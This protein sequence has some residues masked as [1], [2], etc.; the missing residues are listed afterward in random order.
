MKEIKIKK[1]NEIIY[2]YKTKY[3]LDVYIWPYD[4]SDQISLSLN[5]KYGSIHTEFNINNKD[6]KV[7]N[8]IA[9]FLE[10]IKFNVEKDVTAHDIYNKLG[11]YVNAYTTYDHTSYEVV[12][13]DNI[14]DNILNLLKF[15]YN[16]YF[17]KGLISK[18]KPIII[19]EAKSVLDD[20]YNKGYYALQQ[21]IFKNSKYKNIITGTAVEVK[22]IT[23]E[24][25]LNV[26]NGF[27]HPK[28]SFLVVTGNVNPLEV[29]KI[30]DEYF[31]NNKFDEYVKPVLKKVNEDSKVIKKSEIIDSYVTKEK[32]IM[33]FKYPKKLFKDFTRLDLASFIKII[34]IFNFDNSSVLREYLDSNCIID[35]LYYSIEVSEDSV[36]IYFEVS[37]DYCKEVEEKIL[38]QMNNLYVSND[39]FLLQKKVMIAETIL[40]FDSASQVNDRIKMDILN[41]HKIIDNLLDIYNSYTIQDINK[42]ID[43][44]KKY[45]Y[46]KV[47]LKPSLH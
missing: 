41:S 19:E 23:I 25:I 36:V 20:P 9:H 22:S 39:D 24:D 12:C 11:S 26:Y 6:I 21:N 31:D 33:A 8:G 18:E 28:N 43:I 32:I 7:P 5:I 42:M 1:V 45:N 13:T 27:Y 30:V 17:T 44:L 37:T 47:I 4:L 38:N 2:T 15:V 40:G 3:G 34:L 16:P 10:H 14:R 46:A 29:E 35:N